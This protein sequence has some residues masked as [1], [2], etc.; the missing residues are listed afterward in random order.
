[1]RLRLLALFIFLYIGL[2]VLSTTSLLNGSDGDELNGAANYRG[3]A[4][5]EDTDASI[6]VAN[7]QHAQFFANYLTGIPIPLPGSFFALLNNV[8]TN[9][10]AFLQNGLTWF[11]GNS[12]GGAVVWTT[13]AYGLLPQLYPSNIS[14]VGGRNY[15]FETGSIGSTTTWNLCA[16][17][18]TTSA[19]HC[20]V[21]N[22]Y[23]TRAISSVDTSIFVENSFRD[24]SWTDHIQGQLKVDAV[25]VVRGGITYQ[26]S[27]VHRHTSHACG[28][29]AYPPIYN[30]TTNTGAIKG[31]PIN[32]GSVVFR[33][34]GTPITC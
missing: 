12:S 18:L 26:W 4:I 31:N 8:R 7:G 23:G 16:T 9:T 32:N 27:S 24:I 5:L 34:S 19:R 3:F 10:G 1:M 2:I 25:R 14:Y 20:I 15:K 6:Y 13:P 22:N 30:A 17:D 28:A 11:N 21:A 29:G 33:K